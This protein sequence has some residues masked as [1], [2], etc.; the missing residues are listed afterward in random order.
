MHAGTS[1]GTSTGPGKSG[2]W[3]GEGWNGAREEWRWEQ[4]W[5]DWAWEEGGLMVWHT[6]YAVPLWGLIHQHIST[7]TSSTYMA[8]AGG[9]LLIAAAG[10][11]PASKGQMSP[12]GDLQKVKFP[13]PMGCK[14]GHAG[15][16]TLPH[17]NLARI[18]RPNKHIFAI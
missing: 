4:G 3:V 17:G 12:Q 6:L 2:A 15:A 9:S 14:D 16:T 1:T 7:W 10:A 11:Y 8:G 5:E 18:G 13:T